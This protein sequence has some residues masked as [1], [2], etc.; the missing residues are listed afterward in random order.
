M[1]EGTISARLYTATYLAAL[2]ISN[3]W[4]LVSFDHVFKHFGALQRLTLRSG[5][6][7]DQPTLIQLSNGPKFRIF[8]QQRCP[9]QESR[10]GDPGISN[11]KR[12]GRFNPGGLQ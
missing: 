10:R 9:A 11:G 4:R 12:M 7:S 2:T 8:M 6:S 3:G 5:G 1:R